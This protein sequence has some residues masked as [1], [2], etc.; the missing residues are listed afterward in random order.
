M[1]AEPRFI[2]DDHCGRL[3][4]WLRFLGYDCAYDRAID[5]SSLL[6]Q[7]AEGTRIIL[8]RNSGMAEKTMAR[9][10]VILESDKP[11]DQLRQVFAQLNL[12]AERHRIG[13]R[14]SVCNG[15]TSPVALE[16]VIEH[17]P[18]YVQKTHHSFRQCG[19]CRRVYW[20][21]TH[22]D[23]MIS[24]LRTAGLLPEPG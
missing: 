13:I 5:D 2:C 23:K 17:V 12:S 10:I 22:V 1:L 20:Q 16:Q 21:G 9:E 19:D 6:K 4:R 18:P 8:T 11:L 7:A 3:A 24:R 15:A 14:C